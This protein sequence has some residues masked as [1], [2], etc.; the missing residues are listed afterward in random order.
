MIDAKVMSKATFH[1]IYFSFH[2]CEKFLKFKILLKETLSVQQPSLS[3]QT[4]LA[5][6]VISLLANNIIMIILLDTK[7]PENKRNET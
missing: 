3:E 4:Q 5:A 2:A 1:S 7:S 6:G